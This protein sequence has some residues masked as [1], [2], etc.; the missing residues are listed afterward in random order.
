MRSDQRCVY[1]LLAPGLSEVPDIVCAVTLR[2]VSFLCVFVGILNK[3]IFEPKRSSKSQ[4]R[5]YEP[6]LP[7][8]LK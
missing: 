4:A 1:R 8:I 6:R 7:H 3:Y 5:S 2:P